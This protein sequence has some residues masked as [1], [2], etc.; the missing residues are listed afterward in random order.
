[1]IDSNC[2]IA[3]PPGICNYNKVKGRSRITTWGDYINNGR[4]YV[5]EEELQI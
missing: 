2:E 5:T 4:E 3:I 1:M